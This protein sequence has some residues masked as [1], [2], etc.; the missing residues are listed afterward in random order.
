MRKCMSDIWR[1]LWYRAEED[2]MAAD[3]VELLLAA[4]LPFISSSTS[5]MTL[6][7]RAE[8]IVYK[9]SSGHTFNICSYLY[10]ILTHND[11]IYIYYDIY[12]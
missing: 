10:I 2:G 3:G 8:G 6:A 4:R 9:H 1:A 11:T 12:D 7:G 5:M